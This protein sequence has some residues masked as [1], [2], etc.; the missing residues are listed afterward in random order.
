M[1]DLRVPGASRAAA[2]DAVPPHAT[3]LRPAIRRVAD[4][5]REL[6]TVRAEASLVD[7]GGA[8]GTGARAGRRTARAR[9]AADA[10]QRETAPVLVQRDP[11]RGELLL[12]LRRHRLGHRRAHVDAQALLEPISLATPLALVEMRLRLAHLLFAEDVIE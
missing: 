6:R 7:P 3:A 9:R 5:S 12:Q 10:A 4:R 8:Q 1:G 2:R 11:Q